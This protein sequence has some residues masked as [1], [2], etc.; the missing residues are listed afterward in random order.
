MREFLYNLIVLNIFI[1][2]GRFF[3]V[4]AITIYG[5][6]EPHSIIQ[7]KHIIIRHNIYVYNEYMLYT[8]ID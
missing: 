5:V 3:S 4:L 2:F 7:N 8:D 6:L 1:D